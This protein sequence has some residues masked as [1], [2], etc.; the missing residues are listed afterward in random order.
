[1]TSTSPILHLLPLG[2]WEHFLAGGAGAYEPASLASEGFVHC[3]GSDELLLRVANSFYGDVPD[4]IAVLSVDP[5]RLRSAVV[6][7]AP[8]GSDPLAAE[9]FPHV[10]G[11]LDRDAVI[12]VRR[13]VRDPSG[14]AIAIA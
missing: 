7:E 14:R 8:P 12:E 9:R 6:W 2:D 3:T 11:P 1:M 5:S 10:Y 4:P 13:L